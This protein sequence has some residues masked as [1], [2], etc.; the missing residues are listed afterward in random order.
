V[1]RPVSKEVHLSAVAVDYG[2]VA[3]Q[4]AVGCMGFLTMLQSTL[5]VDLLLSLSL[6]QPNHP[7]SFLS[8]TKEEVSDRNFS[9]HQL[10]MMRRWNLYH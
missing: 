6:M 3:F 5:P 9:T 2:V 7:Y 10:P 4:G 8:V 1:H